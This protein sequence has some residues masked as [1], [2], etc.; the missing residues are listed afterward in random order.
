MDAQGSAEAADLVEH[1]DEVRLFCQELGE[2]VGHHEKRGKGHELGAAVLAGPLVIV[3]VLEVSGCPQKLLAPIHLAAQ[4]VLHA[5]DQREVL[6]E[7]GD[8]RRDVGHLRHAREGR[9]AFEVDEHEVELFGGMRHG[10]RQNEG[11]QHLGLS[12]ARRADDEAVRAHSVERRLLDVQIDRFVLGGQADGHAQAVALQTRPPGDVRVE[13]ADVAQTQEVHKL[14]GGLPGGVDGCARRRGVGLYES[15][16][17]QAPGGGLGLN[18]GKSVRP[19]ADRLEADLQKL[20]VIALPQLDAHRVRV[21]QRL[22][23]GGNLHDGHAQNP[24]FGDDRMVGRDGEAVVDDHKVGKLG[25]VLVGDEAGAVGDAVGQK[26]HDVGRIDVDH[27]GRAD[28]VEDPVGAG[29]GKPLDPVPLVPVGRAGEHGDADVGGL[30]EGCD[31]NE[32]RTRHGT[33]LGRVVADDLQAGD[34]REVDAQRQFVKPLVEPLELDQGG[35]CDGVGLG[36]GRGLGL[37]VVQSEGLVRRS[38]SRQEELLVGGL[39]LAH[40]RA[41]LEDYGKVAGVGQ[42][43][44]SEFSLHVLGLAGVLPRFCQVGEVFAPASRDGVPELDAVAV[45]V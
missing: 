25:S 35:F 41:F 31:L 12:G 11:S 10:Q 6:A 4:G 14:G 43:P 32:H 39:A 42:K 21:R 44:L 33:G 23:V 29:V 40:S 36:H 18:H 24:V 22:P 7:V 2:L 20:E 1:I 19:A 26:V 3:D 5:V 45:D 15:L 34:R 27:A 37:C 30:G 8:D 13:V 9:A 38:D 16:R 28:G 17:G